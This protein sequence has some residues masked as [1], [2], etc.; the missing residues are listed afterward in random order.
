MSEFVLDEFGHEPKP[1]KF[2][3]RIPLIW[4]AVLLIGILFRVMH[5]PFG[6]LLSLI[7][8]GGLLAY[9]LHGMVRKETRTILC[10]VL[11]SASAIWTLVL[12]Y[13]AFFRHGHPYNIFGVAVFLVT[14][15]LWYAG[16]EIA[17]AIRNRKRGQ[18]LTN[19]NHDAS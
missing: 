8:G 12:L 17:R 5:Y 18:I 15:I 11:F 10:V 13:G 6:S 19:D 9:S 7:P 3:W 4:F 1:E 2:L 14:A 16:Y